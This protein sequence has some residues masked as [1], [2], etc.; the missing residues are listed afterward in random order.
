METAES[1]EYIV[2]RSE[3]EEL[4]IKARHKKVTAALIKQGYNVE[5]HFVPPVIAIL[6]SG[7]GLR[8]MVAFLGTLSKLAEN[9]FLHLVTYV[10]GTSG[11]TWCMSYLYNNEKNWTEAE[12]LKEKEKQILKS[13]CSKQKAW[14]KIKAAYL[15]EQY[16]LTDFWAYAAV[17]FMTGEMPEE[18]LSDHKNRCEGGNL[19]Y[20][21][22]S[23]VEKSTGTWC[24]FTPH[25]CGFPKYKSFVDTELL[26][27]KFEGGSLSKKQPEWDLCYLRGLWGSALASDHILSN[28]MKELLKWLVPWRCQKAKEIS[29]NC[30]VEIEETE[31]YFSAKEGT[32]LPEEEFCTCN[33]CELIEKIILH[34]STEM[35]IEERLTIWEGSME[36]VPH[37]KHFEMKITEFT[38]SDTRGFCDDTKVL[39]HILV[40]LAKKKWGTT[41]DFLYKWKEDLCPKLINEQEMCLVDAG[42]FINTPYPLMLRPHRKVDLILSF[43]FSSGDP[44]LTLKLA[45]KYCKEHQIPF[46][47]VDTKETSEDIPSQ[48]CYIFEGDDKGAP[49]VMHFPLFNNQTCEGKVNELRD[50]YSTFKINYSDSEVTKLLEVAKKN[51]EGSYEKIKEYCNRSVEWS[52]KMGAETEEAAASGVN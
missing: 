50:E 14:E 31:V 17:Y 28:F 2:S 7:G 6:G 22:Y 37:D 35:T 36:N 10:G 30:T 1:K 33:G 26:G 44:F 39:W 19:P 4:S 20:P 43:D 5:E 16:S 27:S 49:T 3:G 38:L 15:K 47:N 29:M 51:V 32:E 8:A 46:P 52:N 12:F 9:N 18:R 40:C 48:C 21:V 42:L 23:A 41:N 25:V 24:D 11:S 45:A 34:D 13:K